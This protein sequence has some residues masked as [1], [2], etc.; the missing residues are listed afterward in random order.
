MIGCGYR[1]ESTWDNSRDPWVPGT[2]TRIAGPLMV[3]YCNEP[4]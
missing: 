3:R 1:F 2:G 4:K